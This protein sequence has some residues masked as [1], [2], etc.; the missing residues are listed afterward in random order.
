VVRYT[1]DRSQHLEEAAVLSG[2]LYRQR[3]VLAK[4]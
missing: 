2:V 3:Q 4:I 1:A